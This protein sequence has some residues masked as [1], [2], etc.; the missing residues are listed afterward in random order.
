MPVRYTKLCTVCGK[1]MP[2]SKIKYCSDECHDIIK[3]KRIPKPKISVIRPIKKPSYEQL[4]NGR[5]CGI[6][7]RAIKKSVPCSITVKDIIEIT[8]MS[9]EYCG[10]APPSELDRKMPSLGYV[11]SNIAPACHRCNTLKSNVISY[12]DMVK[13]ANILWK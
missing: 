13:V 9:C 4:I 12:D 11:R 7:R 5:L 8:A 6:R 10:C 2:N 3:P 1:K